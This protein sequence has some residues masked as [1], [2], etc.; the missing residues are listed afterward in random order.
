M[1]T[2]RTLEPGRVVYSPTDFQNLIDDAC[3][4]GKA[5]KLFFYMHEGPTAR[6]KYWSFITAMPW[7]VVVEYIKRGRLVLAQPRV[8]EAQSNV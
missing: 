8:Q 5:D 7:R 6:P 3:H 4:S 2:P 1:G